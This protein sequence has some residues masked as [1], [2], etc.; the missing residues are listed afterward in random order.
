MYVQLIFFATM[1]YNHH[2]SPTKELFKNKIP[3][4][5]PPFRAVLTCLDPDSDSHSG[6]TDPIKG[7]NTEYCENETRFSIIGLFML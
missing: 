4:F 1:P 7:K 5:S 6:S 2:K 3:N